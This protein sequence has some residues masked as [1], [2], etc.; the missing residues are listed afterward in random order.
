M[1]TV[2]TRRLHVVALGVSSATALVIGWPLLAHAEDLS[3]GAASLVLV[4]LWIASFIYLSAASWPYHHAWAAGAAA[5]SIAT[6]ALTLYAVGAT[7]DN[8]IVSA[9]ALSILSLALVAYIWRRA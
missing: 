4:V 2:H 3:V 6:P 5:L 1:T 8:A 7:A 9:T